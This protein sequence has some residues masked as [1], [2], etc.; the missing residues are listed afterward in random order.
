M[1][2]TSSP[3]AYTVLSLPSSSQSYLL[4]ISIIKEA[5]RKA[6]LFHHPDKRSGINELDSKFDNLYTIDDIT[7]AYRILSNPKLRVQLDRKL[8]TKLSKPGPSRDNIQQ[9]AIEANSVD[10]DDMLYDADSQTWSCKCRCGIDDAFV[11]RS[12]DLE[13]GEAPLNEQSELLI[14]CRG[15]TL[16]LKVR[17]MII[18]D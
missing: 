13:E 5:Y 18:I 10:L 1:T 7:E 4:S 9:V 14:A 3:D 6:L 11:I 15:C 17:Y 16:W 2:K 8:L 12:K